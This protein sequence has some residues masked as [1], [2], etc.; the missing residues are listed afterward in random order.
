MRVLVRTFGLYRDRLDADAGSGCPFLSI[1]MMRV[2]A[3]TA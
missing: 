1:G 3:L 2:A